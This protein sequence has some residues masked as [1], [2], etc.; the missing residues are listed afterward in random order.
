MNVEGRSNI[1]TRTEKGQIIL[2]RYHHLF[3][4]ERINKREIRDSQGIAKKRDSL[5]YVKILD[6]TYHIYNNSGPNDTINKRIARKL[7]IAQKFIKWGQNNNTAG[8]KITLLAVKLVSIFNKVY[9]EFKRFIR[10]ASHMKTRPKK[11]NPV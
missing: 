11:H 9:R 5:E 2:E 1:L 4:L 6:Q 3:D 10:G 7:L 8:I